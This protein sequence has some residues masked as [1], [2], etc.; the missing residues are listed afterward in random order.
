[1]PAETVAGAK[2]FNSNGS[3]SGDGDGHVVTHQVGPKDPGDVPKGGARLGAC[4]ES[5]IVL[6][7]PLM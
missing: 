4:A 5:V 3:R 1:M 2:C 7:G 6:V